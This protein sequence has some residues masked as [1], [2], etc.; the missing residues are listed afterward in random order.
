MYSSL[1]LLI[2]LRD[3]NTPSRLKPYQATKQGPLKALP[4]WGA[5]NLDYQV[6][7]VVRRKLAAVFLNA[8]SMP[9]SMKG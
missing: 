4:H 9:N 5:Y 1:A 8:K 7:F 2:I 3:K 6:F